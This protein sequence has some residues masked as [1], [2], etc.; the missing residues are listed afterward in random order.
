MILVIILSGFLYVSKACLLDF[1]AVIFIGPD[2][3]ISFFYAGP[4]CM[5]CFAYLYRRPVTYVG[6]G[7]LFAVGQNVLF[8]V[9]FRIIV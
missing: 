3:L 8:I 9:R 1:F 7:M 5:S 6:Y 4:F 2:N